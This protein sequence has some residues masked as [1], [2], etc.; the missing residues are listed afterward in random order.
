MTER[1][2]DVLLGAA[3]ALIGT[4]LAFPRWLPDDE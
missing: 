4:L 1:L 3:L 2:E